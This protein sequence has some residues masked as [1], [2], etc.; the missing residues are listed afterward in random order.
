MLFCIQDNVNGRTLSRSLGR[1]TLLRRSKTGLWIRYMLTQY[2]PV[3]V[4]MRREYWRL[5]AFEKQ[6]DNS[7]LKRISYCFRIRCINDYIDFN[8]IYEDV[9]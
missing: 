6:Q 4:T 1:Y 2:H 9:K 3:M 5:I 7:Q 8:K